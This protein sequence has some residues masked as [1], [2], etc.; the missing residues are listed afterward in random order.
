MVFSL[1]LIEITYEVPRLDLDV[2]SSRL[3][4]K[5]K[6]LVKDEVDTILENFKVAIRDLPKIKFADPAVKQLNAKEGD[7]IE[8]TRN[9]ATAGEAKYY[10]LVVK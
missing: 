7:V 5:Y 9:S 1:L 2:F 6:V 3:S 8:I 4:P 10:R